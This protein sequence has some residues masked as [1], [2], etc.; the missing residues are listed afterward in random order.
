MCIPL[1]MTLPVVPA[2]VWWMDWKPWLKP[3][4]PSF[5]RKMRKLSPFLLTAIILVICLLLSA[6]LGSVSIS[7]PTFFDTIWSVIKGQ[8]LTAAQ[9]PLATILFSLRFPRTILVALTGA[10]LAGSGAAYQGLFRNPMADPYLIGVASG[11]GLGAVIAM[12][13]PST[14]VFN[15]IFIV[16]LAAF[17][18]AL[19]TVWAA[20]SLARTGNSLPSTNLI[21]AGV[22][23]SSFATA[24]TSYL[25]LY[26]NDI[27]RS[28]A[29]LMGGAS[30]SGWQ[31]VLAMLPY[32]AIGLGV[33]LTSGYALNVMQF[34]EEQAQQLGLD[35]ER[36][37]MVIICAASLTAAAAVSF[38]GI[39]G[40]V[41]L[42]VPHLIR[43][44]WGNDYRKLIPLSIL[45]GA[46]LLLAADILARRI[47]APQEIPVGIITAL[48]G[49]PFFLFV[50]RRSR[51]QNVW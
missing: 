26:N 51:R 15:P 7:L 1:M 19:I 42:I 21:L 16:P 49:A 37:R 10:A 36:V 33:L 38:S 23:V 30:M 32:T 22:A 27:H 3:F 45:G 39:I 44:L 28:F 5:S 25:M 8:P 20:Y 47:A 40:F 17:A 6:T 29:W 41:G 13:L 12:T 43:M 35:V 31:P 4:I 24:L 18:G 48:T 14:R 34:G 9:Q 46:A 50:L 11:A 2:P